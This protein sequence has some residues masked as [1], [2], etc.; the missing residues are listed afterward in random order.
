VW[1]V[2]ADV[3]AGGTALHFDG[4]SWTRKDV[5]H[6]ATLWWVFPF[7][8]N[9]VFF[10][11]ASSTI[12]RFDGTTFMRMPTPGLARHTIF[13]LWGRRP[14]DVYAVGSVGGLNGFLWHFDGTRWTTVDDVVGLPIDSKGNTPGLF[15]VWGPPTGSTV[16]VVGG[17]GV[18]LRSL[19]GRRFERLDTDTRG[20][21][22][23]VFADDA[24]VTAV[25]GAGTGLLLEGTSGLSTVA[26]PP[27]V[28]LLQGVWRSGDTGYAVGQAGVVLERRAAGWSLVD[29]RLDVR[30]ESLHATWVDPS[31]A[32]WAVG[33]DVL[34][35]AM[36][37]GVIVR[38]RAEPLTAP[39]EPVAPPA[40]PAVLPCAFETPR[41]GI[42]VARQWNDELLQAIRRDVP[43]P[44]V[45]ARNLFHLSAA[46][47]DAWAAYDVTA[48]GSLVREKHQATDVVAAR[49]AAM[50]AAAHAVLMHRASKAAV[51]GDVSR[52]C[53]DALRAR[54]EVSIE[55]AT[56]TG[57]DPVSV[58][59]RIGKAWVAFGQ[60][61]G[62]NEQNRYADTTGWQSVNPPLVVDEPGVEVVDPGFFQ[63]LNLSEAITQNGIPVTAGVQGYIGA[64]WGGVTP[65]AL[66]Q[67]GG[68]AALDAGTPPGF[69]ERMRA[70]ALDVVR[71]HA[72]LDPA[73]ATMV[74][75][76]PGALGNNPLGTND[77]RG[78]AMNPSTG[79]AYAPQLVRRGD[80]GRVV[81]EYWADGPRSETPP[82]HWNK[83][84]NDVSARPGFPRQLDGR[85]PT[86]SPLDWDVHLYF[87]LNGAMHDAAIAA[88]GIKRRYS[89][90]RPIT[91]IRFMAGKGQCSDPSGPAFH[92][93]GLPLEPGVVEV[94]TEASAAPGQRHAHLRRFV[95]TIAVKTWRGEPGDRQR[96]VAGSDW[97]RGVEWV[98]F[99]RRTF[100]SPAFPGFISGH[101]TY[102]RAGAEVLTALTG[103]AF[104][105]GGLSEFV[106]TKD[107]YLTF[108]R[109]PST[110]VRLQWATYFDAADQAGQSR[111]WGGIHIEPDDF[112]GR[113]VGQDIARR[114]L[115]LARAHFEGRAP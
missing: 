5:G 37:N 98:P 90:S 15:K 12:L 40:P 74:D 3:G 83:I 115:E 8:E 66:P 31:G 43:S 49:E 62:S 75:I 99:Q 95:G 96:E 9:D 100:V 52:R 105:P 11:G 81:A 16:Y 53:F 23:T 71:R 101:S 56:E 107:R 67:D 80:F 51:G 47:W 17:R 102:S 84:A 38:G 110:D 36:T 13:G 103:S 86:R 54:L 14:D 112:G 104:F 79:A 57:T 25:G 59:L 76:G 78:H 46:M 18:V 41:P 1:V 4:T 108:E 92:P 21:L 106:A 22:F 2:G 6:R 88:W 111:L 70:W 20:T 109:G 64:H 33:G 93:Q 19:D 65:F 34:S 32:V 61:D 42:S 82:G 50:T 77:G 24:S 7:S 113:R 44:V 10:G 26:V 39:L 58:G 87:A 35:G 60:T 69:D 63:L 48:T 45:H 89:A 73:D 28:G 72:W 27:D 29:H 55:G 114:A 30:A 68:V 97:L 85:G 91:L 94:I